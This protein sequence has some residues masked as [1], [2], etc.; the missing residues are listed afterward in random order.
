MAEY[1]RRYT[2]RYPLPEA[3]VEYKLEDGASAKAPAKD[4]TQ[5]GLC[6]EFSHSAEKG[7]LVEVILQI[8]GKA[9]LT[10][11]GNIVWTSVSQSENPNLAAIQF[12]P[13]GTDDRYNT[14][15]NHKKLKHLLQEC[16]ED[17]PPNIKFKL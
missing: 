11:K 10:L 14:M 16:L 17:N 2:E 1:E 3:K 6:F 13:F 8:P 9:N 12:L 5:G 7:H 4:I 15:E